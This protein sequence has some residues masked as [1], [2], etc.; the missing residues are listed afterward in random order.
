MIQITKV[1]SVER[2]RREDPGATAGNPFFMAFENTQWE[3]DLCLV[4]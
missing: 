1:P 2:G 3:I 4:V